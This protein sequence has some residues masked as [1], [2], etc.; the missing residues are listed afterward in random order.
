MAG[1]QIN[2][3]KWIGICFAGGQI[4][5]NK[6][7]RYLFCRGVQAREGRRRRA[8]GVR[9]I[10]DIHLY[11]NGCHGYSTGYEYLY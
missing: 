10:L 8:G 1:C 7:D 3:I 2:Q 6:V 9:S 11:I 4:K 5:S